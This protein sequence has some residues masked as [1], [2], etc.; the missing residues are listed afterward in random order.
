[1]EQNVM[2]LDAAQ[3]PPV[4]FVHEKGKSAVWHRKSLRSIFQKRAGGA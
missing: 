2:A 3:P 1:M 4:H